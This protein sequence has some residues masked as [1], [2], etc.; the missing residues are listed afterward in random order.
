[1]TVVAPPAPRARAGSAMARTRAALLAGAAA[2]M[3]SRGSHGTTM[4]DIAAAGGV[5]K[6]TLYNHF[7]SRDEVYAALLDAE[8][9]RVAALV[10][11][12]APDDLA[13]ALLLMVEEVATHPVLRRIA[14]CEPQVLVTL[15]NRQDHP[16]WGLARGSV[17]AAL[18]RSAPA[19]R[20]AGCAALV[21]FLPS[22]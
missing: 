3:A 12:C 10:A 6:A 19:S 15:T 17:V 20:S 11:G 7:R 16:L 8:V 21:E 1:V 22:R 5:A 4:A 13:A 14:G 2:C 18:S 9:R